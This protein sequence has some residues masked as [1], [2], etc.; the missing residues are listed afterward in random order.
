MRASFT[1]IH[2]K[3]IYTRREKEEEKKERKRVIRS[4]ATYYIDRYEVKNLI[5]CQLNRQ[6]SA[7]EIS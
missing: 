1:D 7:N 6:F 2:T 3:Y 5:A 4:L